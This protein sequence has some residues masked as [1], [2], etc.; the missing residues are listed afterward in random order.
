MTTVLILHILWTFILMIYI[1]FSLQTILQLT[2][3]TISLVITQANLVMLIVLVSC[4]KTSVKS[5]VSAALNVSSI[6]S[7][8]TCLKS[9]RYFVYFVCKFDLV[10][11]D[12][13]HHSEDEMIPSI[14]SKSYRSINGKHH[15]TVHSTALVNLC[16]IP[17]VCKAHFLLL[18]VF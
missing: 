7:R 8:S 12:M 17:L 5:S 16:F 14:V 11:V 6:Q 18:L 2:S 1:L 10:K 13:L 3:T 15:L 9:R 4:F